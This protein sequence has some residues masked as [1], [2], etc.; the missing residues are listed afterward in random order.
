M[1]LEKKRDEKGFAEQDSESLTMSIPKEIFNN[2]VKGESAKGS[3]S[4]SGYELGPVLLCSQKQ[5]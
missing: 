3:D 1:S 2:A 4:S 5:Y